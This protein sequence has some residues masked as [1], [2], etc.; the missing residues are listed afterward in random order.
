M[1]ITSGSDACLPLY[2]ISIYCHAY[3][4]I[5]PERGGYYVGLT[6]EALGVQWVRI[7]IVDMMMLWAT[8]EES[9]GY[10]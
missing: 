7:M 9:V 4:A 5:G 10:V 6:M 2:G 8:E 3:V 1:H